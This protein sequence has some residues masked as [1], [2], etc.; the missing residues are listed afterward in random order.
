M[1]YVDSIGYTID[2]I[3][4]P[5]AMRIFQCGLPNY[6]VR[7]YVLLKNDRGVLY[8]CLEHATLLDD[9]PMTWTTSISA[10]F[11]KFEESE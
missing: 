8:R 1:Y 10:R 4:H 5:D 7:H 9:T 6:C 3:N 11:A 2:A